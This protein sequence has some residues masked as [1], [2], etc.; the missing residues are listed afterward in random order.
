MIKKFVFFFF[1]LIFFVSCSDDNSPETENPTTEIEEQLDVL[2]SSELRINPSGYAPLSAILDFTTKEEVEVVLRVV[3]KNGANSDVSKRFDNLGTDFSIPVH[4]LYAN[5]SNTL[6]LTFYNKS[7]Q[8]LG[9]QQFSAQTPALL[10]DLPQITI[11]TSKIGEMEP[12]MTLVSYFGHN[13]SLFPQRPFIFDSFGEIRWYLNF[14]THPQL[15][16]L[17]YDD[18]IERLA[19]GNFYFGSGA[20]LLAVLPI[21]LS[22]KLIFLEMS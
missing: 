21:I 9:T 15:N 14:R 20:V 18:G 10:G 2:L 17:F 13:G 3:G 12:G 4:G 19:N 22:M 7:G 6:E 11:Q 8:N 1:P 5:T 16:Q